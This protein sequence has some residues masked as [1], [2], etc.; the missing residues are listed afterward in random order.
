MRFPFNYAYT[1]PFS[2]EEKLRDL[3]PLHSVFRRFLPVFTI[4]LRFT[5]AVLGSYQ[6]MHGF[7]AI[8]YF[9]LCEEH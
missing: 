1:A 6:N 8:S 9:D 4:F 5:S 3:C 2:L 7:I